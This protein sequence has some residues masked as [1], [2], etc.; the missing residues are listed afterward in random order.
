VGVGVGYFS[1]IDT[2]LVRGADSQRSYRLLRSKLRGP[3]AKTFP[4]SAVGDAVVEGIETRASRIFVPGWVSGLIVLRPLIQWVTEKQGGDSMPEFEKLAQEELSREPD[5]AGRPV[6][7]G[8]E[9]A[10]ESA[11]RRATA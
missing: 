11:R 2:D 4:V 8:G 9:A 5:R 6:G 10:S 1:W 7:A 3:F